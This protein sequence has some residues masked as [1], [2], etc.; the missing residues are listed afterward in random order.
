[1][2]F[3]QV[4]QLQ[5]EVLLDQSQT[6][7]VRPAPVGMHKLMFSSLFMEALSVT[8]VGFSPQRKLQIIKIVA[9]SCQ[10]LRLDG[11]DTEVTE[12][13]TAVVESFWFFRQKTN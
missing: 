8:V 5:E 1:M 2:L 13:K 7:P 11:G 4:S 6:T 3:G 12:Q 9:T 10:I